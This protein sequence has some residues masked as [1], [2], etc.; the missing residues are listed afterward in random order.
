MTLGN[1]WSAPDNVYDHCIS[2][3]YS[4]RG[5]HDPRCPECGDTSDR[6]A[7]RA[8]LETAGC[9]WFR[10]LVEL[11][12]RRRT[13]RF[14]WWWSWKASDFS[15]A[16]RRAV[17]NILIALLATCIV[18]FLAN[19]L[20]IKVRHTEFIYYADDREK[21]ALHDPI[22]YT[23]YQGW[24]VRILTPVVGPKGLMVFPGRPTANFSGDV[25]RSLVFKVAPNWLTP[26]IVSVSWLLLSWMIPA[27]ALWLFACR[28]EA[29]ERSSIRVAILYWSALA[30]LLG[31]VLMV[32]IGVDLT[33]RSF[34]ALQRYSYP[35]VIRPFVLTLPVLVAA[36]AWL[37]ALR[38]DRS[39]RLL[40][41]PCA[42]TL[43]VLV[44]AVV[45]PAGVTYALS[46]VLGVYLI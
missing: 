5:T 30:V 34:L 42:N 43:F 18:A 14:G 8:I 15:V 25:V 28:F 4:M 13:A 32:T 19:S 3:G 10:T 44:F 33:L 11:L 17:M 45:A 16:P 41:F 22:R 36:L 20:L 29:G 23:T 46:R 27:L 2:C 24:T 26:M 40:P 9:S 21:R 12:L 35:P 39:H 31:V 37:R 6:A 38:A 7:H 1:D